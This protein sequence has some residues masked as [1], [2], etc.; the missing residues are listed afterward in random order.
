[1]KPACRKC[2]WYRTMEIAAVCT[3]PDAASHDRIFGSIY[4]VLSA[5]AMSLAGVEPMHR[6]KTLKSCD[7]F[8]WFEERRPWWR[9][10]RAA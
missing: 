4:P 2:R 7:G 3:H 9:F 6:S 10:W 5:P 8:G 1:M